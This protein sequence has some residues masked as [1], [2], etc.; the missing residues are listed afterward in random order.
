VTGAD[1]FTGKPLSGLAHLRQSVTDILTTPIGSRV[2]R[3]EYGSQLFAFVDSPV[4]A[5]QIVRI[6][7]ATA[8]ALI[9]WEPRLSL[10]RVVVESV[11]AGRIT[12]ALYGSYTV[13]G[14]SVAL[15]GI[16]IS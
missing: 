7:A 8:A 6:I 12:L 13:S 10:D 14:E 4:N 5:A 2:M 1:R 15:D 16:L 11:T 3:R 9:K